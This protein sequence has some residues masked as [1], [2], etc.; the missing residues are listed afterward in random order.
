MLKT[1]ATLMSILMAIVLNTADAGGPEYVSTLPTSGAFNQVDVD[2]YVNVIIRQAQ[3]SSVTVTGAAFNPLQT[4]ISH[5]TLYIETSWRSSPNPS[6]KRPL[7]MV[8]MPTLN[9]LVVNGQA[10]VAGTNLHSDGLNVEAHGSGKIKLIG[11]INLKS[12]TQTGHNRIYLRWINSNTLS[13]NS[14]DEGF[15][16]LGGVA[17]TIYARLYDHAILNAQYLRTSIVQVQTKNYSSAFVYPVTTL[18]AFA[19]NNGNIYY[20]AYP[21]N[22]TRYAAQS[23]NV[24]QMAWRP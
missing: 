9:K 16:Y 21:R 6:G 15:I 10:N 22:M 17:K 19:N 1:T 2:G 3:Q 18:R 11:M 8:N 24:L 23:G 4:H 5:H 7:V 12:I 14:S 20:Y 13:V